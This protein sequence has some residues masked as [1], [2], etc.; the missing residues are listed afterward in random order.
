MKLSQKGIFVKVLRTFFSSSVSVE[1]VK[2]HATHHF[3]KKSMAC[4]MHCINYSIGFISYIKWKDRDARE[5]LYVEHLQTNILKFTVYGSMMPYRLGTSKW[6][7]E[8]KKKFSFAIYCVPFQMI[9]LF[10]AEKKVEGAPNI[11]SHSSIQT[12]FLLAADIWIPSCICLSMIHIN[13]D[14]HLRFEF[15]LF[16]SYLSLSLC[17]VHAAKTMT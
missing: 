10:S 2:L 12:M 16:S 5:Y 7:N 8:Q 6:R 9:S 3:I 14:T 4:S 13:T 1:G 15:L 17:R 11:R